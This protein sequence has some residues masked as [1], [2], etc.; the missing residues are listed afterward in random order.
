MFYNADRL[1]A[2]REYG[3]NLTGFTPETCR[4]C[5]FIINPALAA[6]PDMTWGEFLATIQSYP[7]EYAPAWAWIRIN[8]DPV[9]HWTANDKLLAGACMNE[10]GAYDLWVSGLVFDEDEKALMIEATSNAPNVQEAMGL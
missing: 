10:T 6:D 2:L 7:P 5:I 8:F 9:L 3:N 4:I 1:E